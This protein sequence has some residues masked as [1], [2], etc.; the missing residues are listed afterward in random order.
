M[1]K[2]K[3]IT[4]RTP[5]EAAQAHQR[6]AAEGYIPIERPAHLRVSRRSPAIDGGMNDYIQSKLYAGEDPV[7]KAARHRIPLVFASSGS[8]VMR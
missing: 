4:V 3:N 2:K 5:Q 8:E 1:S 6:L 7:G